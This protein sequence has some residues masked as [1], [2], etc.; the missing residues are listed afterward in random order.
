L[1]YIGIDP[2]AKFTGIAVYDTSVEQ[3]IYHAEMAN[4]V[5]VVQAIQEY[6][7]ND[8]SEPEDES[9]VVLEDFL[10]SSPRD[11]NVVATIKIV[12]YVYWT[13]KELGIIVVLV[14]N[15][16]RLANVAN[17]PCDITGKD[18]LAAAAHALSAKE[19]KLR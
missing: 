9:V 10:G 13:C 8:A 1:R 12:G 5:A 3:F 2:G 16:A 6:V 17:V 7:E 4:P 19:R 14:P 18:E 15:Q 11:E